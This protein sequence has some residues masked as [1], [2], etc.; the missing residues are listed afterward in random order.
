MI[1]ALIAGRLHGKVQRRSSKN[2]NAYV[3]AKV[4][5]PIGN[6]ETAFVNVIAFAEAAVTALLALDEGDS[7]A[8]AG[9][10][11]VGTYATKTG[12]TR[13]SLNL[14]AHVAVTEYHVTRKRQAVKGEVV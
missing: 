2:G 6:G 3:T 12:E 8:V 11:K 4:C 5:A 9:E 1:D 7:I 14:T 10:L 13:P